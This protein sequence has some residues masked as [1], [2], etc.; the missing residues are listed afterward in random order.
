MAGRKITR[1]NLKYLHEINETKNL[2][3]R[4]FEAVGMG[5]VITQS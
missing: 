2:D 1:N 5:Q 4:I 3:E